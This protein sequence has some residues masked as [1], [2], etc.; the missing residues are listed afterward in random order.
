MPGRLPGARRPAVLAAALAGTAL[1][2]AACSGGSGVPVSAR[3]ANYQEALAYSQCMR[4]H[5]EPGFPDPQPNGDLLIDG[6]KDHLNAALMNSAS[7]ACQHLM[8]LGPPM[9]AAQQRKVTAE[10]LKFV[11]C[12]RAHGLPTFPDPKVDSRGIEVQVPRGVAQN[13]AVLKNAQQACR[14]LIPGGPP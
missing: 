14:Y 11:A 6:P 12:M 13:S 1:L 8:P 5:G 3:Q 7:K 2:A 10:A 4:T 9:T